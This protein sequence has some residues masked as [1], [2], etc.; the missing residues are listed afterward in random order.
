MAADE[1]PI[2]VITPD[3]NS[4]IISVPNKLKSKVKVSGKGP[5]DI[6][7]IARADAAIEELS[8]EFDGWM[9]EETDSLM[10]A[11]E[12][13]R[14]HGLKPPYDEKLFQVAHDL[15]GQAET[16]GYPLIGRYCASMCKM[17]DAVTDYGKIPM[18]AVA[19]HMGAVSV[20]IRDDIKDE[21]NLTANAVSDRLMQEV[22]G[23]YDHHQKLQAR[24]LEKKPDQSQD[25]STPEVNIEELAK[26]SGAVI[27]GKSKQTA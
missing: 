9:K 10:T 17:F 14:K 24:E 8:V 2:A 25:T 16:L 22:L 21:E 15:R 13:V 18:H 3:G 26:S 27:V 23:F 20:A 1:K 4:L 5:I 19:S 7:A 12:D 11:Y 6:A